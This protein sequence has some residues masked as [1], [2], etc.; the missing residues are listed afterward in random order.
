MQRTYRVHEQTQKKDEKNRN[1]NENFYL[2]LQ[3][4]I[5]K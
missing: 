4:R 3:Y 1:S 5:A 2:S